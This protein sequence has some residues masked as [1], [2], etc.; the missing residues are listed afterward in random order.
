MRERQR[1]LEVGQEGPRVRHGRD[2]AGRRAADLGSREAAL[3]QEAL[4][5]TAVAARRL[6]PEP[7]AVAS[8]E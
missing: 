1:R 6:A 7:A 5:V 3:V 2:V 8:F 4:H